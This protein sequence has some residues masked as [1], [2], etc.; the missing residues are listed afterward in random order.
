MKPDFVL[1]VMVVLL[2]C[3]A[4]AEPPPALGSAPAEDIA[5]AHSI[6]KEL[7][8]INST[9]EFGS[10]GVAKAIEARLVAA[11]FPPEDV[12]FLAPPDHPTKGNLVVR[13]HGK[14][15]D[16]KPLL[17][18]GH[19]DVVEAKREDWSV[20]PFKLTEQD[21]HFYGRGTTDMKNGDAVMIESL[22][23]LR[24]ENFVPDR[25]LIFAFTADEEA[26]G[27]SNGPQWLLKTHHDLI[28][29]QAVLNF[30]A[31]GGWLKGDLRQYYALVT[32]EKVYTTFKMTATSP[33][34]HGSLPRTD[35]PIARIARAAVRL[36]A[37][38]FPVT[39]TPTTKAYF[40]KMAPLAEGPDQADIAAL[41]KNNPNLAVAERLS[42]K[43]PYYH[44]LLRTTC[45]TTL[46]SGG[47]AEN[48]LP[49]RAEATIQ[50]RTMPSDSE[51]NVERQL[52]KV[53]AD[54]E[55][56]LK[57]D[58]APIQAPE[59]PLTPEIVNTVSDTVRDMWGNPP[60]IP[61]MA[62]YF[63]DG[64]QF[65]NAGMPTYGVNG[66]WMGENRTHGKDERIPIRS[67]DESLEF[68]YRLIKAFGR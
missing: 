42:T 10:T 52:R 39:L 50:C 45:I 53:V 54:P 7:V 22:I 27:D 38:R 43:S 36:D 56:E 63:T 57:L 62:P 51:E 9:H 1:A 59:S 6:L 14:S 21:G 18:I 26:G 64:R 29:A 49:Q 8:E 35:N 40:A 25:D 15:P 30:D 16:R 60:V 67:F 17:F 28:D 5:Q 65:R 32:G 24:R 12:V 13:L 41:A 23:R 48:A 47:H 44:A 34:G 66:V 46:I 4:S 55:I 2:V 11:N 33:G 3:S 61:T 58:V 37:Y 31:G 68:S 19:L 20:D